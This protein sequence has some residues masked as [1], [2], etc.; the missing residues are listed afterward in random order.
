MLSIARHK[1]TEVKAIMKQAVGYIR[2]STERQADEGVSLD[3]QKAKIAAW[4][5]ANYYELVT[6]YVDAGISGKRMD[7]RP[8]LQNALKAIKK[9][10]A[11]R[12][13]CIP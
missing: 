13:W 6:V 7:T 11:W 12:W 1:P 8:E 5:A 10:R 4:C 3:A 2:V 9:K